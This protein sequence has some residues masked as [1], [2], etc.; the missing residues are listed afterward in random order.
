MI[1]HRLLTP[2]PTPIPPEVASAEALPI[3]HHRTNEFMAVY[4][5]MA[6]NLKYLFQ[7]N[8]EV[9]T[10][11]SSGTGVMEAAVSNFLSPADEAIV[12]STGNFGERWIQ[13]AEAY[14]A[15]VIPVRAEWGKA[16][17]L[18]S[19]E[20]ALKEHPKAKAAYA[21]FTETSTGVVNDIQAMGK[22]L[23]G[24]DAVL[25]VDAISGL[26]GQELRTDAW[27]V[28]VVVAG[29]QKGMMVAP[30]LAFI[31]VS[32]KAEKLMENV[33]QPLFYF[34]LK[35]AKKSH[36]SRQ[37]PYTPAVTLMVSLNKSLSTVKQEGLETVWQRSAKLAHATQE[38]FK[39]MGL[40]LFAEKPCN[41]ITAAYV[42]EGV[43]GAKLVKQ[44]RERYGISMAGGQDKLKGKIVRLAHMGYMD[45]FDIFV[46]LTALEMTLKKM[47]FDVQ[48]GTG[49]GAA[50]K[51]MLS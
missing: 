11:A 44:M 49:V 30:G 37:T 50:E 10:F 18:K 3:I 19:L 2:G 14:G 8:R 6:E 5:E 26:G 23:S 51:E 7:T 41:V 36:G 29:S 24:S 20:K 13:I 34:N 43:D 28:D 31:C 32:E 27:G 35:K 22:M 25:I 39:A 21:T 9:Y 15:K 42:P 45:Q 38:G 46:G 4:A 33:K 17:D 1:K 48:L 16:T 47:G 40:K 12:A